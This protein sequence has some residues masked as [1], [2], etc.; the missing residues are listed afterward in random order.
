MK[1]ALR[2]TV[3]RHGLPVARFTDRYGKESS[4]QRSSIAG[5]DCIWLGRDRAGLNDAG[6]PTLSRMHLDR[7]MVR[8][9]LPALQQFADHGTLPGETRTES[10]TQDYT[11]DSTNA[12]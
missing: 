10:T 8:A 2:F 7:E 12:A 6:E 3:T 11:H 4:L 1:A 9:L 5:E